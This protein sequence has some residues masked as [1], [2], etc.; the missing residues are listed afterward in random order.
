MATKDNAWSGWNRNTSNVEWCEAVT[1]LYTLHPCC[2]EFIN[3]VTNICAF[4]AAM[5]GLHRA[6]T[7]RLPRSFVFTEIVLAIVAVGSAI[8]HATRSYYAEMLDELPMSIMAYV[9]RPAPLRATPAFC[10]QAHTAIR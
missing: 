3:T 9:A 10:G 1:H 8:F 2:A 4:S 6:L 5:I 7:Y